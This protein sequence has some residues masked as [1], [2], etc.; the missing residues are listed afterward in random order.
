VVGL[1]LDDAAGAVA[2]ADDAADQVPGD[3]DDGAVVEARRERGLA[4]V[5]SA[6]RWR[7]WASCSR[8]RASEVP[9]SEIFDSSQAPSSSSA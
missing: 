8:T 2:V 4:Q 1:G 3:L 5:A 7:A 9:P 6:S